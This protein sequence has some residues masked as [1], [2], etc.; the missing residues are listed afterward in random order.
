MTDQATKEGKNGK[1]PFLHLDISQPGKEP[2]RNSYKVIAEIWLSQWD[3]ANPP[4]RILVDGAPWQNQEFHQ[5]DAQ[6]CLTALITGLSSGAH[7]IVVVTKDGRHRN[8]RS[9]NIP[10]PEKEKPKKPANV[11]VVV[12]GQRGKQ[13]LS[14]MAA[15]AEGDFIPGA[16]G[17]IMNCDKFQTFV[18]G[19]DGTYLYKMRFK[20]ESRAVE[21]RFGNNPDQ[22]WSGVLLGPKPE[23]TANRTR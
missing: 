22:I 12:C 18:T 10:A 4:I 5:L 14:I 11:S 1:K 8:M 17:R 6:R 21:V 2:D 23:M 3:Q 7:T 16:T 20:E 13:K 15:T 9:I 19:T